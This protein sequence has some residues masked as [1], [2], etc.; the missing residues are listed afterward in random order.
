MKKT[1][2]I[3]VT[4]CFVAGSNASTDSLAGVTLGQLLYNDSNKVDGTSVKSP[5]KVSIT[6][7]I[8]ANAVSQQLALNGNIPIKEN[9]SKKKEQ[10][11]NNAKMSSKIVDTINNTIDRKQKI[12]SITDSKTLNNSASYTNNNI[13]PLNW[14]VDKNQDLLNILNKWG[15]T[16]GW[17]IVWKSDYSYRILT[18]ASFNNIDFVTAVHRLFESM[19]EVNPRLYIK[20]YMGN[21]VVMISNKN[22][23]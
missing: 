22:D 2:A 16:A 13:A 23:F 21:R 8:A 17:D 6:E 14:S 15:Q 9:E 10:V 3:I 4:F 1:V 11:I 5:K 7:Q 19:G 20:F 18:A 12:I